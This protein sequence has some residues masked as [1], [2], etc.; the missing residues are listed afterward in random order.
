MRIISI[1]PSGDGTTG[2]VIIDLQNGKSIIKDAFIVNLRTEKEN[3]IEKRKEWNSTVEN[4]LQRIISALPDVVIIED[5]IQ[6]RMQMGK[7]G[8]N[9]PTSEL[10]GI[11]DNR[12]YLNNISIERQRASLLKMPSVGYYYSTSKKTGETIKTPKPRKFKPEYNKNSL[13][14]WDFV[15]EG[16][17]RKLWINIRGKFYDMEIFKIDGK[18]ND[19][20]L[21]ALR[22]YIYF[23][24]NKKHHKYY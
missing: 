18:K 19:H 2:I 13:I 17:Y 12:L 8:I 16:R 15:K 7:F 1:D 10:I 3:A 5:F 11:I 23:L 20:I 9:F 24:H 14:E 4:L 21:M 22:H 6:Y